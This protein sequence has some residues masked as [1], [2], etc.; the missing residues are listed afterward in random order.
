MTGTVRSLWRKPGKEFVIAAVLGIATI[1]FLVF[2]RAIE[3]SGNSLGYTL[4]VSSWEPAERFYA[5][6]LMYKPVLYLFY[7]VLSST[8]DCGVV[9]AGQIHSIL[10]GAVAVVCTFV[11]LHRLTD[12]ALL[13]FVGATALLVSHGFWVFATQL[14]VYVPTVG[15]LL[16]IITLL[17]VASDRWHWITLSIACALVWA[18][19][20][21]FHQANVVLFVP[22]A[23]AVLGRFGIDGWKRLA[24]I[25][26]TAGGLVLAA[27][28]IVYAS[29]DE[30][31]SFIAWTVGLA[32]VPLTD[33]GSL[34]FW[35]PSGLKRA[36]YSQVTSLVVLPAEVRPYQTPLL[37]RG[38]IL[39]LAILGWNA[40]QAWRHDALRVAR[41]TFLAWFVVYFL[42][43]TWWD[44]GVHKFFV[45]SAAALVVLGALTLRDLLVLIERWGKH[46]NGL[47]LALSGTTAAVL[48]VTLLGTFIFNLVAS[49]LPIRGDI[50]PRLGPHYQEAAVLDSITPEACVAYGYGTQMHNLLQYFGWSEDRIRTQRGLFE[51]YYDD[52]TAGDEGAT[53]GSSGFGDQSCAVLR[54]AFI[55]E[56]S[57]EYK[58]DTYLNT[59][60]HS[61]LDWFFRVEHME[62]GETISHDS[63]RFVV[64]EGRAPY[65]LVDRRSRDQARPNEIQERV[66]QYQEE[67][68]ARVWQR[69]YAGRDRK[70]IFGYSGNEN[71]SDPGSL[72]RV[73]LDFVRGRN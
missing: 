6:H 61:F 19:A 39:L 24:L 52:V 55:S 10:W 38:A 41:L 49:I 35:S 68:G 67:Y 30:S 53:G 15:C 28:M 2:F 42:F 57:F 21:V 16:L 51:Q 4:D 12:S 18:V 20:T 72:W 17:L 44:P 54:V 31:R 50:G 62:D 9:C 60:W 66:L 43:F 73:L 64:P 45:P 58:T 22:I 27:Y 13:G 65:V 7:S 11:L 47:R 40:V 48:T 37:W 71:V 5:P 14:E 8:T 33:W 29:L 59:E 23:V 56:P 32:N 69:R 3:L 25:C 70:L 26:G 63:F 46:R 36:L 1:A 34:H